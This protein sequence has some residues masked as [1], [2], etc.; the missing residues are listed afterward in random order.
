MKDSLSAVAVVDCLVDFRVLKTQIKNTE[1]KI[2]EMTRGNLVKSLG[3]RRKKKVTTKAWEPRTGV[4]RPK[5]G[6]FLCGNT[7][8]RMR[9]TLV[10]EM[11]TQ[12]HT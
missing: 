10:T 8:H 3:R 1:R 2:R 6:C 7:E 5:A 4:D 11:K 9:N 12:S